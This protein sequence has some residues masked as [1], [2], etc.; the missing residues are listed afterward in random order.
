MADIFVYIVPLPPGVNEMVTPCLDGFT[1]YI[2][3]ALDPIQRVKAY[4][5]A[6]DHIRK[7]DFQ[8]SDVQEIEHD[9]L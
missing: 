2:S 6:L 4:R 8:K 7:N 9:Q 5:H 3:D 1:I